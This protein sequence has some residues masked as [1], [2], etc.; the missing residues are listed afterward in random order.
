MYPGRRS[1]RK[2][3]RSFSA[4]AVRQFG[5]AEAEAVG[6]NVN[7]LMP[8]PYHGEHDRYL[9][10]YAGTGKAKIIGIGP[11]IVMSDDMDADMAKIRAWYAPWQGKRRGTA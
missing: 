6:R 2:R 5:Y 10:N 1:E 11:T 4:A 7:L 9:S 8:E 3:S